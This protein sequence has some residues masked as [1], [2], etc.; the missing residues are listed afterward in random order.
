MKTAVT[1]TSSAILLFKAGLFETLCECYNVVIAEAVY[2]EM[3][4]AG[5]PGA[6]YFREACRHL[7]K[8]PEP[9][10]AQ[11]IRQR[12]T[13]LGRLDRGE[14]D[15]VILYRGGGGDFV[16]IDDYK[17]AVYCRNHSI[18]YINALLFPRLLYITER[19]SYAEYFVSTETLIRHG[20]Y[21]R[22]I[23]RYAMTCDLN[24][25]CFFLP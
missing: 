13:A 9:S 11:R 6:A 8:A 3:I 18:P 17:G 25:L 10:A 19:L 21:A 22:K 23:I 4:V 24:A 16:I 2:E 7:R 14:R 15:T 1:D 12:D 5:H 20:R